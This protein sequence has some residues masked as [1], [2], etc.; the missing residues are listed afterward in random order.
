MAKIQIEDVRFDPK[1][2]EHLKAFEMRCLGVKQ[3]NGTLK[4]MDHPS[5]RFKLE[6]PFTSINNM[7]FYK[8]SQAWLNLLN[9]N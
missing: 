8:V 2:I 3:P 1:N 5:L 7:L 4:Y 6:K 9:L